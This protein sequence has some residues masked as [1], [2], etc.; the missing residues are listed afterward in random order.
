MKNYK[1]EVWPD[2]IPEF[3]SVE[4][5]W[6]QA[7]I[8]TVRLESKKYYDKFNFPLLYALMFI[9][10]RDQS[11]RVKSSV[12]SCIQEQGL[13]AVWFKVRIACNI[14]AVGARIL[15]GTGKAAWARFVKS[16]ATVA[17][18]TDI[19]AA[20]NLARVSLEGRK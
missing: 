13:N 11:V 7:T 5:V 16:E 6:A 4:S 9:R 8:A 15:F 17:A 18:A 1:N 3:F 10:H 14:A 20:S 12:Q 2:V 19:E